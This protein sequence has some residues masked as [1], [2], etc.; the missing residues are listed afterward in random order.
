MP[1]A[2]DN[3]INE[4]APKSPPDRTTP[5]RV[6]HMI[7]D[8]LV[9]GAETMLVKVAS[10]LSKCNVVSTVVTLGG[11]STVLR[12]RLAVQNIPIVEMPVK[13][14]TMALT[15]LSGLRRI[16][17]SADLIQGWMYHG[18]LFAIVAKT[19]CRARCP[20]IWN[21]RHSLTDLSLES[22]LTRP[23]I[24]IGGRWSDRVAAVINNSQLSI[25]QHVAVGYSAENMVH[26][27]NGFDCDEYARDTKVKANLCAGLGVKP[28]NMLVGHVARYHKMKDHA[29]MLRAAARVISHRPDVTFVM[30]GINVT[31][32][33]RELDQLIRSLGIQSQVRLLGYRDDV[34]QLCSAFDIQVLSSAWGEGFPNIIGE[35]MACETPCVA[36]D[37]GDAKYVV[38]ET[39]TI[40][41]RENVDAL[42]QGIIDLVDLP[43]GQR[44][45]LGRQARQRIVTHFSI[46]AVTSK[47]EQLYR[48][49][50]QASHR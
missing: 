40:V 47:Y 22:P 44:H 11:V 28:S 32:T 20:V 23:V 41:P 48:S 12:K 3:T 43:L 27:P 38:G 4:R 10:E 1:Q 5:C 31:D 9:A 42:A 30:A 14:P 24:R 46:A 13:R 2:V 18:N 26:I 50:I 29:T 33:N 8:L 17:K 6:I 45:L 21:I 36:T 39:G 49:A 34:N 37:V 19:A 7:N 25:Q 15:K 16:I 35:A